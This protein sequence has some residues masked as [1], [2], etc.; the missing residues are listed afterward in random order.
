LYD[1]YLLS[2]RV[3]WNDV[4]SVVEDKSKAQIFQDTVTNLLNTSS[5]S[6]SIN[7]KKSARFVHKHKWF[8]NHPKTH[9]KYINTIKLYNLFL[10]RFL[11]A[12]VNKEAFRNIYVR[13]KD[14]SGYKRLYKG[15]KGHFS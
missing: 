6:A 8:L 13:I 7:N 1:F 14:P 12:F 11:K 15:I 10:K 9:H 5:E 2:K 3:N 4:L